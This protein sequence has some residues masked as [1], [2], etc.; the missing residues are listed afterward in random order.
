MSIL[1]SQIL[2]PFIFFFFPARLHSYGILVSQ[3]G[4]EFW[5]LEVQMQSPNHWTTMEFP[6]FIFYFFYSKKISFIGV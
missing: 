4:M 3:L 5:P 1:I 2:P 6:P